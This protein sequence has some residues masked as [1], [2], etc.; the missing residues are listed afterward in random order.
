[1]ND[2]YLTLLIIREMQIQTTIR[3][4]LTPLM[5]VIKKKKKHTHTQMVKMWGKGKLYTTVDGNV[6]LCNICGKQYG[7]TVS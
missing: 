1:M 4:Y 5:A 7:Y 3:R 2:A 6:N